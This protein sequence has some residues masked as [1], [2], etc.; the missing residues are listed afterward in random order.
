MQFDLILKKRRTQ[1]NEEKEYILFT[2]RSE[3][4]EWKWKEGEN[5][6]AS[7]LSPHKKKKQTKRSKKKVHSL[8]L[9]MEKTIERWEENKNF[10]TESSSFSD[11]VST[12]RIRLICFRQKQ[13]FG[14]GTMEKGIALKGDSFH[15]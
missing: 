6:E 11:K 2:I 7:S 12:K 5:Q 14:G 13:K 1:G 9:G 10:K 4:R 3:A 15:L 8:C